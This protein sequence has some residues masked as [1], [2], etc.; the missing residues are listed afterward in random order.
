MSH[1]EIPDFR[2][3]KIKLPNN[4]IIYALLMTLIMNNVTDQAL[5]FNSDGSK[6]IPFPEDFKSFYQTDK[7][8]TCTN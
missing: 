3:C 5:Y 4:K 1:D 2:L 6:N 8:H 7:S